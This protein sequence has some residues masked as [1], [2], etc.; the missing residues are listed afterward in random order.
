MDD[1]SKPHNK[2]R[3]KL[4]LVSFLILFPAVL[5]AIFSL[6][7]E[8]TYYKEFYITQDQFEDAL[9]Q[10]GYDLEPTKTMAIL[11]EWETDD[12]ELDSYSIHTAP[13][14]QPNNE[15]LD[16]LTQLLQTPPNFKTKYREWFAK[17]EFKII[18]ADSQLQERVI[19]G[20]YQEDEELTKN[21]AIALS[22]LRKGFPLFLKNDYD[23]TT[24]TT[25]TVQQ[26]GEILE[27]L[28]DLI[29][30]DKAKLE[31]YEHAVDVIFTTSPDREL[32]R[33]APYQHSDQA[34]ESFDRKAT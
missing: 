5:F 9:T 30:K 20:I 31:L 27:L 24:T 23:Y 32:L 7:P 28:L 3:K 1:N 12:A 33:R 2:S 15:R 4:L 22:N 11:A 14:N 6:R 10:Q 21:S 8:P 26:N 29:H 19:I 16:T 17:N 25:Y 13:Y 18:V 34:I